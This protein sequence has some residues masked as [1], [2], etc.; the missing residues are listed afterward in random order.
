M[1]EVSKFEP[2]KKNL[3]VLIFSIFDWQVL[4]GLM[5][6]PP[7]WVQVRHVML[8][9]IS[10]PQVEVVVVMLVVPFFVNAFMFWVVDNFL[11]RKRSWKP[12]D[13]GG[14]LDSFS[15]KA[16]RKD[17]RNSSDADAR[18]MKL[19]AKAKDAA[20]ALSS[21][22]NRDSDDEE[23]LLLHRY[24]AVSGDRTK[25]C[26]AVLSDHDRTWWPHWR[27]ALRRASA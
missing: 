14:G 17:D 19:K 8:R 6:L 25:K 2:R 24:P 9:W 13:G 20:E 27:D 10:N 3:L 16:K 18:Y 22:E 4:V 1:S 7:F 21:S 11:M 26:D 23:V 12:L 5:V 15:K